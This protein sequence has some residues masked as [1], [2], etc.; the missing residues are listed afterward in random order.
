M[1]R[2]QLIFF[3]LMCIGCNQNSELENIP[4]EYNTLKIK[5]IDV[6]LKWHPSKRSYR[7]ITT[8]ISTLEIK[9]NDDILLNEI[10]V[11][12]DSLQM[13]LIQLIQESFQKS[14]YSDL[15]KLYENKK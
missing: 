1:P 15:S 14:P 4:K 2:I 5:E 10:L 12:L 11:P 6:G 7:E 3:I 8:T 13:N 9:P